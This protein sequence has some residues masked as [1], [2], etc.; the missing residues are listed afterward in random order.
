MTD[1]EAPTIH[2]L[3]GRVMADVD[4]V[5]KTDR[6]QQ[7]NF[8]FRGIDAVVNAV[9]PKLRRHG[10]FMLPEAGTPTVDQYTSKNG[11]QM[12]HVLLPVTFRFYGPAGDSVSCKVIGEAADAGDK[13]MS[14]AHAVAW[15][16]ALLECF[17]IPTDDP[18]PDAA[19][20]E[21]AP[22]PPPFDWQAI[23]WDD[24]ADHDKARDAIRRQ[25]RALPEPAKGQVRKWLEDEGF[26]FPYSRQQMDAWQDKVTEVTG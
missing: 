3:M 22:E 5:A 13:V 17:A 6:N 1:T 15:R 12:T 19:S 4:A 25:A 21:R 8:N 10:V 23:G 9:G 16:V 11:A 18:D 20:H 24:Q 26:K 2:D 14:K 7:Q